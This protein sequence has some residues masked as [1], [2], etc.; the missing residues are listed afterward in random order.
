MHLE[1]TLLPWNSKDKKCCLYKMPYIAAPIWILHD[2][3]AKFYALRATSYRCTYKSQN[4][5]WFMS[6][7]FLKRHVL[8]YQDSYVKFLWGDLQVKVVPERTTYH[9]TW[10]VPRRVPSS[11]STSRL[12]S[13]SSS[14]EKSLWNP[15]KQED[16]KKG[17]LSNQPRLM[18]V[19]PTALLGSW[20]LQPIEGM[21][22]SEVALCPLLP[23]YCVK[24]S[25]NVWF[26]DY[27]HVFYL[28]KVILCCLFETPYRA[29]PTKVVPGQLMHLE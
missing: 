27:Q 5:F 28:E 10:G 20:V 1:E 8:S 2:V 29:A 12:C 3:I 19:T 14:W 6:D 17:T 22:S 9:V 25:R 7:A 13:D 24:L 16:R 18:H 23:W 26:R 15:E 4:F 21:T 11:V